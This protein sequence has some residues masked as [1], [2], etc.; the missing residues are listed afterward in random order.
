MTTYATVVEVF[1][2]SQDT[3]SFMGGG[4]ERLPAPKIKHAVSDPDSQQTL[5]GKSAHG[6]H[7]VPMESGVWDTAERVPGVC[8]KCHGAA[9]QRF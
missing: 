1:G 2:T 9:S 6:M 8:P 4:R 7:P 3:T 5:C